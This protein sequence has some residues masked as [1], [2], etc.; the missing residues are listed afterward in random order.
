MVM[1]WVRP[2]VST[3]LS[4]AN[5]GAARVPTTPLVASAATPI[6]LL[7]VRFMRLGRRCFPV[8]RVNAMKWL[9]LSFLLAYRVS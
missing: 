6:V 4:A 1:A 9:V 7:V 2:V 8:A 3:A 5:A